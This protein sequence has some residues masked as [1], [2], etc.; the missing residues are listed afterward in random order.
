MI[1]YS[2]IS[3]AAIWFEFSYLWLESRII[4]LMWIV[5]VWH[6]FRSL[7]SLKL[8]GLLA[9]YNPYDVRPADAQR[10]RNWFWNVYPCFQKLHETPRVVALVVFMEIYH[11]WHMWRI[12]YCVNMRSYHGIHHFTKRDTEYI[13]PHP[14]CS[15]TWGKSA[16]RMQLLE[17]IFLRFNS[18]Y[19]V[20]ALRTAWKIFL[21]QSWSCTAR[22]TVA[23]K[24][25]GT[26][27][28]N[29]DIT[30]IC[31]LYVFLLRRVQPLGILDGNRS[32]P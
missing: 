25:E 20:C 10:R 4:D 15:E 28:T 8:V 32:D 21:F 27:W 6:P 2:F 13:V 22:L 30:D 16:G 24:A 26:N 1:L 18:S 31:F 17:V 5:E 11:I 19:S 29:A 14:L 23:W 7:A 3:F 12:S 9:G